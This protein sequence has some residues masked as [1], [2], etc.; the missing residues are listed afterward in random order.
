M[1]LDDT[2]AYESPQWIPYGN[3][4]T[5]IGHKIKM[6]RTATMRQTT[7]ARIIRKFLLR[8]EGLGRG[9]LATF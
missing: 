6:E 2:I 7:I 3:G 1:S 5:N 9:G 8:M 4:L